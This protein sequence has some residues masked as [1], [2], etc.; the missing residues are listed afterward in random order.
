VS[1]HATA[2]LVFPVVGGWQVKSIA[3]EGLT[4][5]GSRAKAQPLDGCRGGG[6]YLFEGAA[7]TRSE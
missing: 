4:V 1:R 7:V 3:L 6:I 5:D 2:R